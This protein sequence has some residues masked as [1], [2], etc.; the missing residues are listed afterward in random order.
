MTRTGLCSECWTDGRIIRPSDHTVFEDHEFYASLIFRHPRT[1]CSMPYKFFNSTRT[2]HV[3][4]AIFASCRSP[5]GVDCWLSTR[6]EVCGS[7]LML[8]VPTTRGKRGPSSSIQ[9]LSG[10]VPGPP[11]SQLQIR[12]DGLSRFIVCGF[13]GVESTLFLIRFKVQFKAVWNETVCPTGE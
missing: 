1:V 9:A 6:L 4:S 12:R 7:M 10:G 5:L 3:C 13:A 8:T 2:D 11:H